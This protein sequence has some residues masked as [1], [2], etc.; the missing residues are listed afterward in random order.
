M[1]EFSRLNGY[2]VKDKIARQNIGNLSELN[3]EEKSNLV[4]AVNENKLQLNDH[5]ENKTNKDELNQQR[6]QVTYNTTGM[7]EKGTPV[8]IRTNSTGRPPIMG[9]N[10]PKG[11]ATYSDRDTAGLQISTSPNIPLLDYNF[12]DA[13]YTSTTVECPSMTD[14]VAE[15]LSNTDLTDVIIDTYISSDERYSSIIDSFD[16]DTK[17]FTIKEGWFLVGSDGNTTYTPTT[18]LNFRVG[19]TTKV[20]GENIVTHL[21]D[22]DTTTSA[23]VSEMELVSNKQSNSSKIIDGIGGG[24]QSTAYGVVMRGKIKNAYM[25]VNPETRAF[26]SYFESP[27]DNK[28]LLFTD[29]VANQNAHYITSNWIFS[30]LKF[31]REIVTTASMTNKQA[32]IK[33]L[34]DSTPTDVAFEQPVAGAGADNNN[35]KI[36]IV[37]NAGSNSHNL[38]YQTYWNNTNTTITIAGNSSL[39]LVSDGDRW[40]KISELTN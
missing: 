36:L 19:I 29:T 37:I 11:C 34:T 13:I 9:L 31:R 3:T 21:T 35:G 5:E 27:S 28:Y 1:A 33:F 22:N 26:Y 25:S 10:V 14:E 16:K 17:T 39:I 30:D 6:L 2:D 20:W 4:D 8:S 15:R 7:Y 40:Y 18:G 23:T 38:N 32:T 24:T 12:D